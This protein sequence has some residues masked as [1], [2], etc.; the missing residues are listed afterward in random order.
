M[1]AELCRLIE[2][3]DSAPTLRE[4]SARADLI[5]GD[6]ELEALIARVVGFDKADETERAPRPRPQ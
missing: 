6:G 1:V 5:G 3:A 4:L 2:S